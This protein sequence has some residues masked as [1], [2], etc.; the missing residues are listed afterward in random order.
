MADGEFSKQTIE[1]LTKRA[2]NL[3]SNPDCGALTSG[4]ADVSDRSV[5]IGEAAHIYGRLPASARYRKEMTNAERADSTNAIWLCRNC[6]KLAD[7]DAGRFPADVL[8][9][10]RRGHERHVAEQIGQRSEIVR[11]RILDRQLAAFKDA[12]YLAQQIVI[13]K[14]EHWE[15]KLAI[16]LL[17]TGLGRI[18]KR[19]A[20]IDQGLYAKP[21]VVVAA[22]QMADWNRARMDDLVGQIGALKKLATVELAEAFGPPGTPGDELKILS[23]CNL[24]AESCERLLEW[25]ETVRF[26]TL[27]QSFKEYRSILIGAGARFFR[28]VYRI[29]QEMA[30]IFADDAPSGNHDINLVFDLPDGFGDRATAAFLRGVK[31]SR[32]RSW[33]W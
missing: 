28:V 23:T 29:P 21:Y 31:G 33:R 9:E 30:Q 3:C 24:L 27:P 14:P 26:A 2:G 7:A 6:H 13:D 32:A 1:T 19:M 17:R 10:W 12:S 11:Q 4:P 16:E 15:F 5:T 25:E 8:F 18:Q 22:E 20:A